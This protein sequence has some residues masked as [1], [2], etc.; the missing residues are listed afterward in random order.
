MAIP[1]S[2]RVPAVII[3]S[4]FIPFACTTT[5]KGVSVLSAEPSI[6][7]SSSDATFVRMRALGGLCVALYGIGLPALFAVLLY[8][9]RAAIVED[10]VLRAKGEGETAL[11]N[12]NITTRRRFRKL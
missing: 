3:R 9:H 4:S 6:K 2:L 1:P 12:P 10:Q 8:R 5:S 11:T 7:C